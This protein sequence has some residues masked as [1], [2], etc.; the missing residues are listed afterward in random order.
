MTKVRAE[1]ILKQL[2]LSM[3]EAINLLLIQISLRQ[4]LTLASRWFIMRAVTHYY[5]VTLQLTG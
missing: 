4:A 5:L 3:S 1:K 2:G